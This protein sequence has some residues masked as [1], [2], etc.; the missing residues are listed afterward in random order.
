M[1]N[2]LSATVAMIVVAP[3]RG[4][5]EVALLPALNRAFTAYELK[6]D[7]VASENA[8]KPVAATTANN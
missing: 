2:N 3:A 1:S 4:L 8:R 6:L 5:M 7:R